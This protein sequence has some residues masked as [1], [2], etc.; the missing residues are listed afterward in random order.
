MARSKITPG[1]SGGIDAGYVS[2]GAAKLSLGERLE[3]ELVAA[4][5]RGDKKLP[6]RDDAV[7]GLD[8]LPASGNRVGWHQLSQD[9]LRPL[10][11]LFL[12][13]LVNSYKCRQGFG[14]HCGVKR[15]CRIFGYFSRTLQKNKQVFWLY[16]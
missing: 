3:M 4:W 5:I 8:T 1:A 16:L 11:V 15:E 2:L 13:E 6:T 10:D 7:G 12:S 9:P 14:R